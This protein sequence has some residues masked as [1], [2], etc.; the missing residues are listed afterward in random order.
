M[1]SFVATYESASGQTRTMTIKAADLTTAKKLLRRRGIRATDLKAALNNK[2][3]ES[4]KKIDR[5]KNTSSSNLGLFF[6]NLSAA[7]EKSPGVKDKAVFASKLATLVD[8]GVPIVRS[9]D[10]MASQQRL[11]MFKRALMKVS[12]DVN[13]GSAM[14]IAMSKWPKVFDQLSVAMVEAGEAGGV[15]D[16]S[17]KRLAKLLEDN[18]RLK[19]QIKGALGYPVTVL[20]IAI[21][22]FLGMTI[23]LIPTF[24]EIFED[25]GAELPMFTQF[26]VDLSK[27]L[28][29]SFSLLL[30]GVLLVC[31]WIFNR[32]YSTHQGRRQI[33]RLKLRIPLFGNLIIKTA[34]AQFCRIF[35]SLIRA[36][37]PILMSLE[38]ASETAGN[39]IISD[40]ILESRTLVQEGVL[41][42][43]ALIRQKVLPDMALS[44]LAIGEETG[45]MDQMLSKVAD[46]YE[47]EV[48]TS[49]K[50][51]T[52]MLEPAMIVVV[53]GIVGSILL[54]MYL[55]MFTVFDQIQ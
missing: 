20:V 16:E 5:Q 53:G 17:L 33:D 35:S 13:E 43:A 12:L 48:S 55:P 19:N 49:V 25:L 24:A 30:T 6:I 52:S 36:G 37:V 3:Q 21:L 10:L 54:A 8:A 28:R 45:E 38:I 50:A 2:G 9:L 51:L 27:L 31:A 44:M 4:S 32:Y 23:F 40:A 42:S 14:G 22:V 11:P 41:L 1:T 47:D 15:L 7:F 46:F 29:S 39:A 26:M 34:T 18:A